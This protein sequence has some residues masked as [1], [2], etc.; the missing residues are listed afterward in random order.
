VHI[1]HISWL[2]Y[3]ETNMTETDIGPYMIDYETLCKDLGINNEK[4]PEWLFNTDGTI[5][6]QFTTAEASLLRRHYYEVRAPRAPEQDEIMQLF[7]QID[8]AGVEGWSVEKRDEFFDWDLLMHQQSD[9]ILLLLA[10]R[11]ELLKFLMDLLE[12]EGRLTA[13]KY[14]LDFEGID[15]T[16][17]YGP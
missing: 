13:N 9:I 12:Y 5:V 10:R 11:P 3:K 2:E 8:R 17:P 4:L 16:G 14:S 1:L 6:Q 15:V 7:S